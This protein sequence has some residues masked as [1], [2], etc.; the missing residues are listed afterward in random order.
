[1]GLIQAM[2]RKLK[3]TLVKNVQREQAQLRKY[4]NSL[5][6]QL[7]RDIQNGLSKIRNTL[8]KQTTNLKDYVELCK[9]LKES[10]DYFSKMDQQKKKLEDMKAV[11]GKYRE[12]QESG[13]FTGTTHI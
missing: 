9:M 13:G 3:E 4:L 7:T 2:G 11:L 12:K 1:M 5:A 6:E 8:G 10:H